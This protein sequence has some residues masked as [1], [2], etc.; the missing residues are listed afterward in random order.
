[1]TRWTGGYTGE[2]G[3]QSQDVR[4]A[5][6][7]RA[8]T[9]LTSLLLAGAHAKV[10]AKIEPARG[11]GQGESPRRLLLQ[12]NARARRSRESGE[13]RRRELPRP[14]SPTGRGEPGERL[15]KRA[16]LPPLS[17]GSAARDRKRSPSPRS[18]SDT[19]RG[20]PCRGSPAAG[21]VSTANDERSEPEGRR[22]SAAGGDKGDKGGS[23]ARGRPPPQHQQRT[24]QGGG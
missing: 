13:R 10:R 24:R 23:R 15:A 12:A 7:L 17:D 18:G 1:M 6:T 8:R 19:G 14:T 4:K 3:R 16:R 9:E 5:V 22:T 21:V 20:N 11:R 2:A